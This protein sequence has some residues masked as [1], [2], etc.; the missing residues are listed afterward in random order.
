MVEMADHE[1]FRRIIGV[2]RCRPALIDNYG[3]IG[4]GL[5]FL[6]RHMDDTLPGDS[7]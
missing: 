3:V 1:L 4:V 2:G 6:N 5:L 7:T